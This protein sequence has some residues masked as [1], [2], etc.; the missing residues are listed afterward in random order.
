MKAEVSA[1]II[2]VLV[3]AASS[4]ISAP[5]YI[6]RF[7]DFAILIHD[8]GPGYFEQLKEITALIDAYSLQ[9][10]TYLF[11][12][13]NHGGGMPLED[14]PAFVAFLGRLKA[15]GYHVELHGYTHIGDEFDCNSTAAE[16]KLELGLRALKLLNVT[17]E[18]FIAPRYSLSE[19][20]LAV[21]LSRNITVIGEDFVYFPNGTVEPVC[22]R[23]YTWY[24]PSPFL[25]Y[26]LVSARASY[27]HTRGTFFLSIHPGAVNNDA[28]M[29]FLREFLGFLKAH[30]KRN[31]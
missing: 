11:V 4:S 19:D 26:Q 2:I 6:P 3:F 27:A 25:D 10:V 17:P 30:E 16:E 1:I 5:A 22:N 21:L 15:E 7:G 24:L 18:Y 20:A 13:P 14:Y 31:P 9:N 23:E 29:E 28:G 12:I 8:V